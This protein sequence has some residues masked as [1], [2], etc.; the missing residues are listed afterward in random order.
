MN[1][2]MPLY[3]LYHFIHCSVNIVYMVYSV[4][5][6]YEEAIKVA[7]TLGTLQLVVNGDVRRLV[8]TY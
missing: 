4:T 8:S 1:V 7:Q 6:E 3:S 2:T 5:E